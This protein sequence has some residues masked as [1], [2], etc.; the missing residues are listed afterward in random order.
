MSTHWRRHFAGVSPTFLTRDAGPDFIGFLALML[1]LNSELARRAAFAQYLLEPHSPDDVLP[2]F[3]ADSMLPRYDAETSA[4]YRARLLDR[5]TIW[6]GGDNYADCAGTEGS[7]EAQCLAAGH[8]VTVIPDPFGS[9]NGELNYWSQFY[10]T[11]PLSALSSIDEL[12]EI[13][14]YF[15]QFQYLFRGFVWPDG[16]AEAAAFGE[17]AFGEGEFG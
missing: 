8:T 11:A 9:H 3:G 12:T 5:W 16:G 7:I 14:E 6:A 4:Q 17:E 13:V 15:R 2:E 1:D 10:V